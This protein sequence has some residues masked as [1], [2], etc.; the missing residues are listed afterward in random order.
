VL[1]L[2]LL[3]TVKKNIVSVTK[4]MQLKSIKLLTKFAMMASTPVLM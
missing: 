4:G 3:F 2:I 1:S